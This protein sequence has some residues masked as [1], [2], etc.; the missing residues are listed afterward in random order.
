MSDSNYYCT[1]QG[2]DEFSY[3]DVV[4]SRPYVLSVPTTSPL[5]ASPKPVVSVASAVPI[6]S[7]PNVSP[8]QPS[9]HQ[10]VGCCKKRSLPLVQQGGDEE[11]AW[12]D[13]IKTNFDDDMTN[14][15]DELVEAGMEVAPPSQSENSD[16]SRLIGKGTNKKT[17]VGATLGATSAWMTTRVIGR[18]DKEISKAEEV[19]R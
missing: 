10:H 17:F 19:G 3:A 6:V 11:L 7:A 18:D 5:D 15:Y 9:V 2:F 4:F 13:T 16:G 12:D 1:L 14:F 8:V